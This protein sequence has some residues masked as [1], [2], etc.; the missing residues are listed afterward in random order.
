MLDRL[1]SKTKRR[2]VRVVEAAIGLAAALGLTLAPDV[3]QAV[4]VLVVALVGIVGGEVAQTK[5]R[6]LDDD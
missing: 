6:P 2:P 5:T 4:I 3:E 1:W